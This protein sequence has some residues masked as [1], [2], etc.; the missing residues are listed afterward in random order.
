VR[1]TRRIELCLTEEEYQAVTQM[2]ASNGLT[3]AELIRAAIV[4]FELEAGGPTPPIT[5]GGRLQDFQIITR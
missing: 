5:L 1:A 4:G 3:R 2:A